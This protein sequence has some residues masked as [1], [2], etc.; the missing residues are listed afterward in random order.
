MLEWRR[1]VI[2]S[3]GCRSRVADLWR[4]DW[5]VGWGRGIVGIEV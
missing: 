5:Q 2:F 1:G 3:I 4:V